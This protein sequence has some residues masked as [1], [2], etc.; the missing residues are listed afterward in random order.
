MSAFNGLGVGYAAL[1][2]MLLDF[3]SVISNSHLKAFAVAARRDNHLLSQASA[4]EVT[5]ALWTR[6]IHRRS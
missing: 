2:V 3:T 6:E 5:V 4:S 1:E